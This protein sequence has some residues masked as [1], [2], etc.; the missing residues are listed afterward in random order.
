[1][2][3]KKKKVLFNKINTIAALGIIKQWIPSAVI[4]PSED[5]TNVFVALNA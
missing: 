2:Q 5:N 1:M 3:K 4:L